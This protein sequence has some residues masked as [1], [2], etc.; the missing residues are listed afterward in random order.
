MSSL[1]GI[2]GASASARWTADELEFMDQGELKQVL[3]SKG[4]GFG[5][6]EG[7]EELRQ[8]AME[9]IASQGAPKPS[10]PKSKMP[11]LAEV[12]A[13]KAQ[14]RQSD[15]E[16]P[17]GVP[18]AA[19][20]SLPAASKHAAVPTAKPTATAQRWSEDEIEFMDANELRDVIQK[21][22][23]ST[24]GLVST[25]DLKAK[26]L[27]A[28]RRPRP[29]ATVATMRPATA[30]QPMPSADEIDF[31]DDNELRSVLTRAGLSTA[32]L[33][34][35]QLKN[36]ALEAARRPQP[37][38][39]A[40]G[41]TLGVANFGNSPVPSTDEV[42]MMDATELRE[43]LMKCGMSADGLHTEEQLRQRALQGIRIA[44][45]AAAQQQGAAHQLG[46]S[47]LSAPSHSFTKRAPS[48]FEL[49]PDL[50]KQKADG[51]KDDELREI[52]AGHG[53]SLDGTA[54]RPKLQQRAQDVVESLSRRLNDAR[55]C[56]RYVQDIEVA[57]QNAVVL[58]L[59]DG[60]GSEPR[61][62]LFL[63]TVTVLASTS[64]ST[65]MRSAGVCRPH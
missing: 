41:S 29:V 3:E 9:A 7:T 27:E 21:S 39:A 26:A 65:P 46:L 24:E 35:A 18:L 48:P 16:L 25:A 36:A 32:G 61:S 58:R 62:S 13:M 17:G 54:D 22:G 34:G 49:A 5:V 20:A 33:D 15:Q 44:Q 63:K 14:L 53:G 1:S 2:A 50:L 28:A 4:I 10:D 37:I 43:V 57:Q 12:D 31:M 8:R 6:N 64:S 59:L 38:A 42:D 19:I 23:L 52:I 45:Q 60:S 56:T 47:S 30:A 11:S 55:Q 40:A 51:M